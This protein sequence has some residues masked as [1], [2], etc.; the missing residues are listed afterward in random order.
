MASGL[1]LLGQGIVDQLDII[2][3]R[4][5]NRR[6]QRGFDYFHNCHN[7]RHLNNHIPNCD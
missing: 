1:N 4:E 2:Q 5:R 7:N 3:H 6:E